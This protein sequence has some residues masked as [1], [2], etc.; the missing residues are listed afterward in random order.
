[1]S[2]SDTGKAIVNA[3]GFLISRGIPFAFILTFLLFFRLEGQNG[4]EWM[5]SQWDTSRDQQCYL[6]EGGCYYLVRGGI[7]VLLVTGVP[8]VLGLYMLLRAFMGAQLIR[9]VRYRDEFRVAREV[10]IFLSV[11]PALYWFFPDWFFTGED[12][13]SLPRYE[14]YWAVLV[15]WGLAAVRVIFSLTIMTTSTTVWY[16]DGTGGLADN[17]H[18]WFDWLR[19]PD[20]GSDNQDKT[21]R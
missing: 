19:D 21:D 5:M 18:G 13:F 2:S 12:A 1:M 17:P 11:V 9:S 6:V 3:I 10:L 20:P 16:D 14:V 7:T 4:I 8:V 15:A